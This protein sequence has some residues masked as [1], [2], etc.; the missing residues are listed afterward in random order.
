[1]GAT[2]VALATSV[3][4]LN[5]CFEPSFQLFPHKAI[6][7]QTFVTIWW[8][9]DPNKII[10]LVSIGI[11]WI[12]VILIVAIEYAL[13]THPQREYYAAPTPVLVVIWSKCVS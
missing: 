6:A 5:A 4:A 10:A 11:Q 2:G 9:K 8:L 12:F 1:M 7:V 13:H 3:R